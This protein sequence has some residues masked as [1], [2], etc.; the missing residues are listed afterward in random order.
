MPRGGLPLVSRIT[1]SPSRS[2]FVHH[3]DFS[4][5]DYRIRYLPSRLRL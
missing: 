5:M 2:V 3:L 1:V 4:H